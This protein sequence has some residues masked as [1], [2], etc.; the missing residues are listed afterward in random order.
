MRR[1]LSPLSGRAIRHAQRRLS[2][3]IDDSSRPEVRAAFTGVICVTF[4]ITGDYMSGKKKR[5][6]PN[7]GISEIRGIERLLLNTLVILNVI[8]FFYI[9]VGQE[10]RQLKSNGE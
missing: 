10:F 9:D 1:V 6:A 2:S 3:R 5:K 8:A 4:V 7:N